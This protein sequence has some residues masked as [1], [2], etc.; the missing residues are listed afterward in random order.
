M[1]GPAQVLMPLVNVPMLDYT[2]ELLAGN[3][4]EE[5]YVTTALHP[6]TAAVTI[7]AGILPF[8]RRQSA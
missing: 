2:I 4:V 5:I 6:C 3:G 8:T 7:D 1:R